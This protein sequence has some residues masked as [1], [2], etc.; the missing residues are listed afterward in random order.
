M[1]WTR[2]GSDSPWVH[3]SLVEWRSIRRKVGRVVY[4]LFC[5]MNI[6]K[7]TLTFALALLTLPFY[8]HAQVVNVTFNLVNDNF[9]I[10]TPSD[11]TYNVG[12]G[13]TDGVNTGRD[14]NV[15][16][17]ATTGTVEYKIEQLSV[18]PKPITYTVTYSISTD[19]TGNKIFGNNW[20]QRENQ[21]KTYWKENGGSIT[22]SP[23]CNGIIDIGQTKNCVIT[24]DDGPLNIGQINIQYTFIGSYSLPVNYTIIQKL[25]GGSQQTQG[26]TSQGNPGNIL[27][28]PFGSIDPNAQEY[29]IVFQPVSQFI[30]KMSGDCEGQIPTASETKTCLATFRL[31]PPPTPA[32]TPTPEIPTAQSTPA[33]SQ[34]IWSCG[35]Y[36]ICSVVGI[37][38]RSCTKT[39]DCPNVQTATPTTDQPCQ[40]TIQPKSIQIKQDSVTNPV[41]EKISP[42][43]SVA[44]PAVT[45]FEI[46]EQKNTKEEKIEKPKELLSIIDQ[47]TVSSTTEKKETAKPP[48]IIRIIRWFFSLF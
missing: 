26:G 45:K 16:K 29:H 25:S 48:V 35:D 42:K 7:Y 33:C 18:E 41:L 10:L 22:F 6:K 23:E 34:D 9:G 2:A 30:L 39:F 21:L 15:G 3:R 19:S 32:S 44:T 47:N 40:P 24:V 28:I 37:Q 13:G 31:S 5:K 17:Q 11:F 1:A 46:K 36:G 43:K 4:E 14:W 20:T 38:S 8:T 12:H 27:N